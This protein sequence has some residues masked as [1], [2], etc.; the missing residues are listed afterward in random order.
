MERFSEI[1]L[2]IL[3]ASEVHSLNYEDTTLL[4]KDVVYKLT[5]E[6]YRR[7]RVKD[8]W[9]IKDRYSDRFKKMKLLIYCYVMDRDGMKVN[10]EHMK[11]IVQDER[12][13]PSAIKP[14]YNEL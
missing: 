1:D 6:D 3:E 13:K 8:Y 9:I 7:I 5:D 14:R 4:Y 12:K 10:W 2:W 11:S